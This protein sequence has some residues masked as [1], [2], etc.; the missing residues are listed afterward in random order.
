M[1]DIV[2]LGDV[3]SSDK[4]SGTKL[5]TGG[6]RKHNM[7]SNKCNK[8]EYY[9]SKLKKCVNK[10]GRYVK[11]PTDVR[12]YMGTGPDPS[13]F[14]LPPGGKMKMKKKITKKQMKKYT[15]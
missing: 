4:G 10:E 11:K 12:K 14:K 15:T 6:R 8:Y 7:A 13:K 1:A 3:S 5:K 9:D 2:T